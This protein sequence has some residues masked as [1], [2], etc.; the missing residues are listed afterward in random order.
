MASKRRLYKVRFKVN[1]KVKTF[2][3]MAKSHHDA[4]K[5]MKRAGQIISVT[6]E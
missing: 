2:R 5:R 6:R 1:G 4:A 3:T